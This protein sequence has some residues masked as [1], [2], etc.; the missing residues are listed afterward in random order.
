MKEE[1][2]NHH[3]WRKPNPDKNQLNV[4]NIKTIITEPIKKN[5]EE[6]VGNLTERTKQ[7]HNSKEYKL[8][9]FLLTNSS[10]QCVTIL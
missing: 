3:L 1:S 5:S 9:I 6:T 7:A 8:N 10:E 2:K 4:F